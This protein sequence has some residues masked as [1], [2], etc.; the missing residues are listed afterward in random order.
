MR[1]ARL[2]MRAALVAAAFVV[3]SIA[4]SAAE[5]AAVR[6]ATVDAA[7]ADGAAADAAAADAAAPDG[8]GIDGSGVDSADAAVPPPSRPV[9]QEVGSPDQPVHVVDHGTSWSIHAESVVAQAL[10]DA[11]HEA[12]GPIVTS[13]VVLDYPYTMSVH[14]VPA[15]RIL[16][17]MLDGWS[18]TLHYAA[19]GRLERVRV[20]SPVPTR[21]F[22]TPRL[23]ESLGA[24]EQRETAGPAAGAANGGGTGSAP[25]ANGDGGGAGDAPP[26]AALPPPAPT[27]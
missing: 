21:M 14:R 23:A 1:R 7:A 16:E 20:Y 6:A 3:V 12:G 10:F 2:C 25:A 13:K 5:D 19:N 8:A 24:W 18:Y 15:E 27:D 22:K 26:A 17:R 9:V 4:P 11:W